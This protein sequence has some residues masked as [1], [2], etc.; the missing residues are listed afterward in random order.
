M[1]DSFPAASPHGPIDEVFPDVFVVRGTMRYEPRG[2]SLARNM[3][4]VRN[5]GKLTLLN[6]VRLDEAGE[7]ALAQLG[8]VEHLVKLG[9]FH[10]LD[11]PY[12]VQRYSPTLWAPPGSTHKGELTPTRELDEGGETPIPGAT[13]FRFKCAAL[14]EL[15]LHLPIA[16]GTLLTCDS[17]TNLVDHAG[18][19]GV[20]KVV[21][22]ENGFLRRASIGALWRNAMTT[23]HGPSLLMDYRRLLETMPFVNLISAHGPPLL[24]TA[25]ADLIETLRFTFG[26]R[27]AFTEKG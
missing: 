1:S 5:H 23:E 7:A 24:D 13:V 8:V 20:E 10:G 19:D 14:P 9:A 4:V 12:Y 2:M 11:D 16:G 3:T 17:I 21:T 18:S 25:T 15:A 22:R 6:A 26:A 27:I